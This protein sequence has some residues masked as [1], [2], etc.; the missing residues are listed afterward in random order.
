MEVS[1]DGRGHRAVLLI[2]ALAISVILIFSASRF[3]IAR[4]LLE[5]GQIP[6]LERSASLVPGNGEV[7]DDLGRLHQ[8]D[9][10]GADLSVALADFRRAVDTDPLSAR[11]W[12]DL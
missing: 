6:Q 7:W 5:S 12:M 8:W 4:H 1:L 10:A 2:G 11:Y 9:L 3:W